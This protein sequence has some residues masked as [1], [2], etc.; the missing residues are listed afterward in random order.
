MELFGR[1]KV[2]LRSS[3][4]VWPESHMTLLRTSPDSEIFGTT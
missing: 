1:E 4:R 2:W 3:I